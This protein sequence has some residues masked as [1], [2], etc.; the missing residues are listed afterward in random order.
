MLLNQSLSWEALET[1]QRVL[2]FLP[3]SHLKHIEVQLFPILIEASCISSGNI[4]LSQ[5]FICHP[6]SCERGMD[7]CDNTTLMV[8][9]PY[10]FGQQGSYFV[11]GHEREKSYR[12][13]QSCA[14]S[15]TCRHPSLSITLYNMFIGD[16]AVK[17]DCDISQTLISS[18]SRHTCSQ[19]ALHPYAYFTIRLGL[20]FKL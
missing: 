1:K 5:C 2:I 16:Q 4:T 6:K 18:Y 15:S 11:H 20:P 10:T 14:T 8:C 19:L 9:S 12:M 3:T 7:A 17:S 13:R